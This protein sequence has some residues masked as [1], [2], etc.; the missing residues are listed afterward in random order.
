MSSSYVP[1]IVH[2]DTKKDEFHG[3]Y[4][5]FSPRTAISPNNANKTQKFGQNPLTNFQ[6]SIHL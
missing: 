5:A 6:R 2:I 4:K 3:P 1:Y